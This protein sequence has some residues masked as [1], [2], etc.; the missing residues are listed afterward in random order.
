MKNYM[1]PSDKE[2]TLLCIKVITGYFLKLKA[3]KVLHLDGNSASLCWLPLYFK[4]T[5][6]FRS[7][8]PTGEIIFFIS[9]RQHRPA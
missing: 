3:N 6:M 7:D 9:I 1:K 5:G 8:Y 4:N 2:E